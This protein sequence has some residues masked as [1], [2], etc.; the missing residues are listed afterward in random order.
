MITCPN[1]GKQVADDTVHCGHCGHRIQTDQK[2]TML[3]MA[4]INPAE[5]QKALAQG[6]ETAQQSAE[7]PDAPKLKLP[8]PGDVAGGVERQPGDFALP[9]PEA[10]PSPSASAAAVLE[11]AG[12]PPGG[13]F[14]TDDDGNAKTEM[15]P[16]IDMRSE[17]SAGLGASAVTEPEVDAS[18][19]AWTGSAT[20]DGF[21]SPTLAVEPG[22]QFAHGTSEAVPPFGQ[23]PEGWN[24]P[25]GEMNMAPAAGE[26]IGAPSPGEMNAASPQGNLMVPLEGKSNKKLFIIIGAVAAVL[27]GCCILSVILNFFV[28]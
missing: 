25:Q 5:L 12:Q 28:F 19:G 10:Q 21:A 11:P 17:A 4:A 20:S 23:G 26:M 7:G 27:F 9:R 1:C 24:E 13:P 14:A 15:L 8:T 16:Q 2:K 6:R 3:G 22:P 18:S